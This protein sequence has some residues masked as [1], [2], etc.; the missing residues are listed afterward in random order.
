MVAVAAGRQVQGAEHLERDIRQLLRKY[1][2]RFSLGW[3]DV[4]AAVKAPAPAR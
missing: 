4:R 3:D 2:A 1:L